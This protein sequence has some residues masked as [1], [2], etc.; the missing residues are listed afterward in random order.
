MFIFGSRRTLNKTKKKA[1]RR[2]VDQPESAEMV[3]GR[4]PELVR[5]ILSFVQRDAANSSSLET[6]EDDDA[7]NK[8]TDTL[9]T[10]LKVNRTWAAVAVE[11]LHEHMMISSPKQ[12][13]KLVS[14]LVWRRRRLA[15]L[16]RMG[17]AGQRPM[18]DGFFGLDAC[19]DSSQARLFW[20]ALAQ[21]DSVPYAHSKRPLNTKE[22]VS[23]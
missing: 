23:I 18:P 9:R 8:A 5:R 16:I 21:V 22:A 17:R 2:A 15:G 10:A 13:S 7:Y 1:I 12:L 20:L 19:A 11:L 14:G 4:L 3:V 6:L